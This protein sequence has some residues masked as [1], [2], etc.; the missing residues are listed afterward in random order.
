MNVT[1]V[2][3]DLAKNVFQVHRVIHAGR[4][5]VAPHAL[6]AIGAVHPAA[7]MRIKTSPA[8][9]S[10]TGPVVSISGPPGAFISMTLWVAGMFASTKGF[11][12]CVAR[13]SQARQGI[14]A[15]RFIWSRACWKG[16]EPHVGWRE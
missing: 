1:A 16:H 10:G 7:A 8:F 14:C 3:I 13:P 9:G 6:Q 15:P 11:S 4:H 2:G 5:R 12:R